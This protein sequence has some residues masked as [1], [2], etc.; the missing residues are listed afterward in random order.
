[1]DRRLSFIICSIFVLLAFA[2][3]TFAE[4]KPETSTIEVVGTGEVM[5]MP[6]LASISFAVET[7]AER[8]EKAVKENANRTG[9]LLD[10]LKKIAGEDTKIR[11]SGFS[12][13]PIYKK[14]DR[15][16]PSGYRV[17]N[18]VLLKTKNINKLGT[19][20][21]EASKVGVSRI[22]SLIFST[23]R[24]DEFRREAAVKALHQAMQ[25]AKDLAKAANLTIKKI[26]RLS[27]A[28]TGPVRPYRLEAMAAA[29]RTPIEIGQ[30]PITERVSV[31]FAVD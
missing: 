25:I 29:T 15:L 21:D 8:A 22:G 13:S 12:V 31:V 2:E 16:R 27:Y 14:E 23:D 1:M 5:V 3:A 4:D 26:T 30:I 17:T 24:E 9:K 18:T 20:I 10:A 11:T 28:P 7:N 6:N 19:L